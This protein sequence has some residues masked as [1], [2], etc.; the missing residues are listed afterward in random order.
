MTLPIRN[1]RTYTSSCRWKRSLLHFLNTL[2]LTGFFTALSTMLTAT[3]FSHLPYTLFPY[4]L[5]TVLIVALGCSLFFALRIFV[6]KRATLLETAR[7]LDNEISQRTAHPLIAIALELSSE[8][9]DPQGEHLCNQVYSRAIEH[10]TLHKSRPRTSVFPLLHILC[11]ATILSCLLMIHLGKPALFEY[12]QMPLQLLSKAEFAVFPGTVT[13]PKNTSQT[14]SMHCGSTGVPSSRLQ[15]YYPD[16]RTASSRLLKPDSGNIFTCRLDSI[17]RTVIYQF[18]CGSRMSPPE[19][20][21]VLPPPYLLGLSIALTPPRYTAR[22]TVALPQGQGDFSALAGSNAA[23]TLT[24]SRLKQAHIIF[25][26]DTTLLTSTDSSAAGTLRID[27][28]GQYHFVLYD[29]IGQMSDSVGRFT[30]QLLL[31]EAPELR[32]LHPGKNREL[33][34]A[35]VETLFVEGTDDLGIKTATL[36][37]RPGNGRETDISTKDIS[38]R[39]PASLWHTQFIWKLNTLSLYPG[40]TLFY[41]VSASDAHPLQRQHTTV[42]DTFWFRV[43]TFSEMHRSMAERE[44]RAHDLINSVSAQQ[45]E[46]KEELKALDKATS[47]NDK[48]SW[49]Q[50]ELADQVK[51]T[52]QSQEDTLREA[53]RE[54]EE[55]ADKLREE[56]A[57]NSDLSKKMEEI[58]KAV[59]ELIAQYGDSLLFPRNDDTRLST[60]ELREAVD[61]LKEMLPELDERLDNTLKYLETLKKDRELA[62]LAMQAEKLA[63]EQAE[64]AEKSH[65]ND[66]ASP[67]KDLL[68]RVDQLQKEASAAQQENRTPE[69]QE[70]TRQIDA[71][72]QELRQEMANKSSPSSGKMQ[73]LSGSLASLAQSLREQTSAFKMEQ[74]KK[75]RSRLLDMAGSLVNLADW[76][77]RIGA[78]HT[79]S[80][81]DRR[82]QAT[83]EQALSQALNLLRNQLDSLPMLPPSLKQQLSS[84]FATTREAAVAAVQSLNSG[85]GSFVMK[86]GSQSMRRM[87]NSALAMIEAME[88]QSSGSCQNGS[89]MQE[90]LR[91]MSGKQAAINSATAELLRQMLGGQ[92]QPG[93]KSGK[94][95]GTPGSDAARKEAQKQQQA[96]AEE[97]QQL[98]KKF[99]DASGTSMKQRI[100]ELE[101]EA[102]NLSAMLSSP[103]EEV[104]ERQDRFLARMLQSALSLHREE[105]GKEDRKS[106][107]AKNTFTR[108]PN[109][110][111]DSLIAREDAFY[112]LR[113]KALEH[114]NYPASYRSSINAYFDSLS[115]LY[116]R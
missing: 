70:L 14:L 3:L 57:L 66:V 32:I 94:D 67:E 48:Q 110:A 91:K 47:R 112:T 44:N 104:T 46:L 38:P 65:S 43:P 71:A 40:D 87:A 74:M 60:S 106:T 69:E 78:D 108:I 72:T 64:L 7:T 15:L 88:G 1:I 5:D 79:E 10:I 12:L 22:P 84:D 61:K 83:E 41:W 103:R 31:D 102:R 89:G 16:T 63:T 58:Q 24:S 86:I 75:L 18:S 111:A 55:N 36:H 4:V 20:L 45:S 8:Q 11:G 2:L 101:K 109:A 37:W 81:T 77:D 51:E 76:Q 99:G 54:L 6:L 96:L 25:N 100:D 107:T 21:Q 19:T 42:T 23:I 53:L 114:G 28:S 29:T 73:Q 49:E 13:V 34:P 39:T 35:Q 116:L 95:G 92:K 115:T 98:G 17:T 59:Q 80:D 30:V 9:L 97:L 33:E 82:T 26:G 62:M 113:K 93:G 90:S 56:G 52:L 85:E 50:K 27:T 105:E 68:N